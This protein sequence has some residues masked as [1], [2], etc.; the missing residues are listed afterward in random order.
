MEPYNYKKYRQF[1]ILNLSDFFKLMN[2]YRSNQ[3][4]RPEFFLSVSTC[5]FSAS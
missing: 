1:L 2:S 3:F 4:A 5:F